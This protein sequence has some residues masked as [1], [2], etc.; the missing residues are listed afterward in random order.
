MIKKINENKLAA[1]YHGEPFVFYAYM[2]I[3]ECFPHYK[4][5]TPALTCN[6]MVSI[7]KNV[8]YSHV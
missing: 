6:R 3:F 2:L 5:P 8:M 1:L 4:L 7:K